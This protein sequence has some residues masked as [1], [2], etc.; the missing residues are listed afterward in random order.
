MYVDVALVP[1]SAKSWHSLTH[2]GCGFPNQTHEKL[3][4]F[5]SVLHVNN[6]KFVEEVI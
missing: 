1:S 6:W 2:H 3:A 4:T 5:R